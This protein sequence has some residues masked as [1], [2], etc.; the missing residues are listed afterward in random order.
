MY[1]NEVKA[2]RNNGQTQVL[3]TL[4]SELD[5]VKALREIFNIQVDDPCVKYVAGGLAQ[6]R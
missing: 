4:K 1:G 5:R 2:R 3:A 6:L